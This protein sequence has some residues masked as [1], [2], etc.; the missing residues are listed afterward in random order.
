MKSKFPFIKLTPTENEVSRILENVDAQC[1]SLIR[2]VNSL[3]EAAVVDTHRIV[4]ASSEKIENIESLMKFVKNGQIST[5]EHHVAMSEQF[6][7]DAQSAVRPLL[8]E[9][10]SQFERGLTAIKMELQ[11]KEIRDLQNIA[12]HR[13]LTPFHSPTVGVMNVKHL[14]TAL[15]INPSDAN[16]DLTITLRAV[17]QFDGKEKLRAGKVI[18]DERFKRL[19]YSA[20]P[21]ILLVEGG[22]VDNISNSRISP[23]SGVCASIV[24]G[25][26]QAQPASIPFFFMCGL[27]TAPQDNLRGPK[28]IMRSILWH[29]LLELA[30][31]QLANLGF[32]ETRSYRQ[33]LEAH[34]ITA[35]CH[36]FKHLI[37]QF[38]LDTVVYCI[39]DGVGWCEQEQWA[40][41][42][43]LV[44]DTLHELVYDQRLRPIF[45]VL[46]TSP[47][48]CRYVSRN[49]SMEDRMFV[50]AN[51]ALAA[52]DFTFERYSLLSQKKAK[53]LELDSRTSCMS[54]ETK[55][56]DFY[57]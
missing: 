25:L 51:T 45:K 16:H 8:L 26:T 46:V 19:C 56:D 30:D 54:E 11:A 37:R 7:I 27:H 17:Q 43:Q 24:A 22:S 41:D 44:M 29:V 40:Q 50:G 38:P 39:L 52:R 14:L 4:S 18:E 42:V 2:Y 13:S 5:V 34:E 1:R 36:T 20:H 23:L 31:R 6:S 3:T 15:D 55:D 35:L 21:G 33:D 48:R 12:M 53:Y 57:T 9:I 47:M 10:V 49:F 28:G 32:I